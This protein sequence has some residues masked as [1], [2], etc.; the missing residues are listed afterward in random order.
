[1]TIIIVN[2]LPFSSAIFLSVFKALSESPE[3]ASNLALSGNHFKKINYIIKI[4]L[5]QLNL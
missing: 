1:M 3:A 5:R 2:F 4:H